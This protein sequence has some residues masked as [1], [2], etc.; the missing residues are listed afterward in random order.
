MLQVAGHARDARWMEQALGVSGLAAAG[1][2]LA[3]D[4]RWVLALGVSGLAAGARLARDARW[5]L[6]QALGVSGLA[7]GARLARDARW[8]LEQALGVSGLAQG[9]Q[10]ARDAR[11]VLEQAL[12]VS[13]LAQG[14][15]LARDARWV[16]EQA[17][18]VSGLA[19]GARLARDAR[20]VLE[21]ALGVSG[22]AQGAQLAWDA[23]WVLEQ[24]LGVSALAQ[25][26]LAKALGVL[27]RSYAK[28]VQ[29]PRRISGLAPGL[30]QGAVQ[31]AGLVEL[32][33]L[34]S[35]ASG[36]GLSP[37]TGSSR[38]M[39]WEGSACWRS[40]ADDHGAKKKR[41]PQIPLRIST[42]TIF[43]RALSAQVKLQA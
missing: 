6:G 2:R 7:A 28:E 40:Q 19:A 4:A 23:R 42:C 31:R 41:F 14:A 11:W 10:L 15:Q 5:V 29:Q 43:T 17:L 32:L 34:A 20:W 30:A 27:A 33:L 16:L 3:R 9:A 12:G 1:A 36:K 18:R 35:F 24:A 37:A 25:G 26:A 38:P 39:F 22:L 13:G 21:Q 8:V